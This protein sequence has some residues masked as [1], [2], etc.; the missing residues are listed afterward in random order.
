MNHA[1]PIRAIRFHPSD[2][3]A[4]VTADVTPPALVEIDGDQI[5]TLDKIPSGHKVAIAAHPLGSRVVKYGEPIGRATSDIA[6]GQHV[7][8]HNVES[9]RLPGP[10][11]RR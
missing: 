5:I 3:V 4:V 1:G 7:H 8:V 6:R 11:A 10:V 9:L 2:T